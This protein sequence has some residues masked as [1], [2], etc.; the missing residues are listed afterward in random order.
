MYRHIFIKASSLSV[1]ELEFQQE[2][3]SKVC[4]VVERYAPNCKWHLDTI[5]QVM[6]TTTSRGFNLERKAI[7]NLVILVSNCPALQASEQATAQLEPD[8]PDHGLAHVGYG[9]KLLSARECAEANEFL[10]LKSEAKQNLYDDDEEE[11]A[12]STKDMGPFAVKT[13]DEIVAMLKLIVKHD[14]SIVPTAT[15]TRAAA[16]RP[17]CGLR[18]TAATRPVS[19]RL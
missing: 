15:P 16:H 3:A 18:P 5:I 8:P 17:T 4:M 19:Q 10:A 2:L 11:E 12:G 1:G 13:A 6:A 9:D 14:K 7:S